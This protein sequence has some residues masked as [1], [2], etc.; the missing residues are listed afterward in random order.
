MTLA[1]SRQRP[2]SFRTRGALARTTALLF[3]GLTGL[4]GCSSSPTID[5]PTVDAATRSTCERLLASFPDTVASEQSVPV[6][7][8]GSLGRA[9]GD[10]AITV[11]C[12]VG[13]PA[14]FVAG[15][16]C[17]RVEGVD[18]FVPVPEI[19]DQGA[20]A[21]LTSVTLEPRVQ[22][23]LPAS[24]RPDGAAAALID[25]GEPMKDLLTRSGRCF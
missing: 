7:P 22:V 13:V 9:W 10:P 8:S 6:K 16:P 25:L 4:A 21:T 23:L 1:H 11:T 15:S 24:Y 20:D 5:S 2:V 14:E 3:A 19:D 12:G 17:I 18:W